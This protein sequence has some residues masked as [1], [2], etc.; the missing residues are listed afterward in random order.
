MHEE[1]ARAG[2]GCDH[3]AGDGQDMEAPTCRRE[4]AY[5]SAGSN[6]GDRRRNLEQAVVSLEEAGVSIGRVSSFFETEPVGFLQQPWFLNLALQA[7]TTLT[8]LELLDC[9]Q[10]IESASGRMRT[11]PGAP[12]TLDL[13]ILFFGST[14]CREERLM[15]PHPRIADRRFVLEPLRQIAPEFVHPLLGRTVASLLDSCEDT[16]IVRLYPHGDAHP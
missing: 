2:R 4:T 15:L 10:R 3:G 16:S 13:D 6:I 7:E 12:R 5:I 8:P 1:H 9:C 11:F 14:V